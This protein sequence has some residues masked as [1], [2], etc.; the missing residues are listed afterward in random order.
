MVLRAL[1]DQSLNPSTL[2]RLPQI[3]NVVKEHI[4]TNLTVE[5]LVALAGFGVRTNRANMQML[6]LPGRF[7][8]KSEYEASYWLPSKRAIVR[9]MAQ[10]FGV[11]AEGFQPQVTDPSRLRVAIQDSTGSDRS[12]LLPLIRTLEKA[13]YRNIFISKSWGEPLEV[14]HIVAQQGD[15]DSAES[16]RSTLGF[17]EVRVESTGNIGSDISIQI[18]QDWLQQKSLFEDSSSPL[19]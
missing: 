3:L 17:G 6:M 7:S 16:I 15:G 11:E 19:N 1:I 14:T 13:G 2:S 10:H 12:Q 5:E 18:G 8:E 9:L 4:D